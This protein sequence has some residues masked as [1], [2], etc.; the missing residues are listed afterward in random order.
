MAKKVLDYNE[1]VK[2]FPELKG[3]ESDGSTDF[4]R[5]SAVLGSRNPNHVWPVLNALTAGVKRTPSPKLAR[6]FG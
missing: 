3:F 4:E 1:V 5:I 6:L 2:V